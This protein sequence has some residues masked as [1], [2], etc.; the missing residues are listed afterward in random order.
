[1]EAIECILT[2]RS[3]RKYKKEKIPADLI[4]ELLTAAMSAPSARNEQP[5]HF[6]VIDERKILDEIPKFHPYAQMLKEAPLAILI[7]GDKKL[8]SYEGYLIQDCSAATQN[9][10][11]ACHA[12]GL[13]AVWIGIYPREERIKGIKNLLSLPED[14]LPVSLVAIGYPAEK[15]EAENRYKPERVHHNRW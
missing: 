5:W 12:Q 1:M 6:I 8:T 7:A 14:I 15:K 10:L 3:I 11:L 2:R 9:L 4:R 13:G